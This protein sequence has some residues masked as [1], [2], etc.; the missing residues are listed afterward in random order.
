MRPR[1][2]DAAA[3]TRLNARRQ[4]TKEAAS[5]GSATQ[6]LRAGRVVESLRVLA[7]NPAAALGPRPHV[8]RSS[9]ICTRK[10]DGELVHER[11][12]RRYRNGE[13]GVILADRF[14][15]TVRGNDVDADALTAALKR[16]DLTR[17]A[18]AAR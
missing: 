12:D 10:V 5:G 8:P 17:L 11:Y 18:S 9:A 13:V 14:V 2:V 3:D 1:R 6:A 16:V 15:V 7:Q 4:E